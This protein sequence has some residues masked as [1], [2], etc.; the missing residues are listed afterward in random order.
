LQRQIADAILAIDKDEP[1]MLRE[2]A[3]QQTSEAQTVSFEGSLPHQYLHDAFP[4]RPIG[5]YF[6]IWKYMVLSYLGHR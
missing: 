5:Y 3:A 6:D 2:L 4:D 1:I